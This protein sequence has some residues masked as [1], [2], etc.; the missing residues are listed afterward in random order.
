[1]KKLIFF[2]KH[3][4]IGGLEKALL[5]L[6]NSLDHDRY[7]VTLVLE[8]KQGA[9]LKLLDKRI[10]V[11]KYR[12]SACPFVP[13]RKM[14]NFTKRWLWGRK[15]RDQY[16]FSCSYC[17]Y[18]VI[19]SRL[20]QA[21]S[22]NS[23][24]Y[25]HNDY[26]NIYPDREQ[27]KAFFHQLR[28][29]RFHRVVFVSNES[30]ESFCNI[31]PEFAEKTQVINNIINAHEIKALAAEQCDFQRRP[32][33]TVFAFVGRLSEP[34]KRLS[35][36]LNAFALALKERQDL[37]L[38]IVG[39]G[40][41]RE[42]CREQIDKLGLSE[43]VEMTGASS[44]PYKYLSRA[45]C[46]VISSDYEGFPVVYY[47]ALVL[48]KD[49]ITTIPVSDEQISIADYGTVTD[50]TPEA[51]ATAMK[52]YQKGVCPPFDMENANRCRIEAL[53]ELADSGK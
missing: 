44:N 9:F 33:E 21:A 3:M 38:L 6:L 41:D 5:N 11:E 43:H 34:H 31:L 50:K 53:C 52:A 35:R 39:D 29:E 19:G 20:S 25:V 2:A 18:S 46:L 26:A 48:G 17:T 8:E 16:D 10:K 27:F 49:I 15:N 51:L 28:T 12:L 13:L 4:E 24:L 23:C 30:R 47:E 7:Q 45:D 36:L 14:I 22:A 40:P 42:L 1:M 37:R 32:E